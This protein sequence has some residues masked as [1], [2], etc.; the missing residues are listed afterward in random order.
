MK[1]VKSLKDM[2]LIVTVGDDT[3]LLASDILFRFNSNGYLDLQS[4][5]AESQAI[6]WYSVV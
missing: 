2:D 1:T 6:V 5:K 3:T 4:N